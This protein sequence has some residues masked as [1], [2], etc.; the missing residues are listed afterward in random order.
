[1]NRS[2]IAL[3]MAAALTLSGPALAGPPP[4][5]HFYRG[6]TFIQRPR[7]RPRPLV[8][9]LS[10]VTRP[11][12]A[13]FRWKYELHRVGAHKSRRIVIDREPTD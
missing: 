1:M 6:S 4:G 5:H 7:P 8:T 12:A 11:E 10:D 3:S 2:I 13:S 9:Q